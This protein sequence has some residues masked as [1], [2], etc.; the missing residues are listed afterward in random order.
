MTKV[1]CNVSIS[2]DGFVA[3]PQQSMENPLGLGGIALH[4]WHFDPEGVEAQIVDDWLLTPGAFVMGRNMFT[5][6]RGEWDLE[7]R[8]WW[9]EEP[10]YHAPVFVLT[11][12]EREP[13]EMQGGTTFHFVTDGLESALDKAKQAAGDK[14]VEV[15]GGAATI[16]GFLTLGA[17]DEL[18]LHIAPRVLGAGER[19]FDG[20]PEQ[21][22]VP[23]D[24]V[25]G[26][27][28]T[29]VTYRI[30]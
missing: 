13:L 14:H 27:R 16:N 30:G 3:G 20:V 11:H 2:A 25:A 17:I 4:E 19:L 15:A 9:G 6:G 5:A 29:H 1:T 7:W 12:F 26:A 28:A 10:P 22:L 8:G 23:I 18:H 24:V 21:A